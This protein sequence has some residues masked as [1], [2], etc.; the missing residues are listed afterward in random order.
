MPYRFAIVLMAILQIPSCDLTGGPAKVQKRTETELRQYFPNGRAIVLPEQETIVAVTC[1]H[2]LGKPV[3]ELMV[4][5]LENL[6]GIQQLH[7]ARHWPLK[8]SPYHFLTLEFEEYY[9]RLDTDTKQ[10]W[11]APS[12]SQVRLQYKAVCATDAAAPI[13]VSD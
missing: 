7:D 10:R 5:Y 9:I 3:I 13:D 1:T 6:Q 11:L 2:G 8:F 12:D 4:K